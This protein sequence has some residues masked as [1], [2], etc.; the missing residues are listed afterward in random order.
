MGIALISLVSAI[1]IYAG[2]SYSFESEEFE[3]Y[4][5]T[6]NSSNM[7]GMNITW[8]DGN[9]TIS[10]VTNFAPDSFTIVLFNQESEVITQYVSSG[11]GSTKY[12]DREVIVEVPNYIDREVIKEI[13]VIKEVPSEPEIKKKMP[14][15]FFNIPIII[16]YSLIII[17]LTLYFLEKRKNKKSNSL[18]EEIANEYI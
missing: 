15:E 14:K 4:T 8:E 2:N 7:E 11:G 13:E 10:F 16:A 1:T 18:Q 6:G 5:I 17:C 3:Y 12:V 9:T